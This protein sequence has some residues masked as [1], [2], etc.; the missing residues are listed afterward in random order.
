MAKSFAKT[1]KEKKRY[2]FQPGLSETVDKTIYYLGACVAHFHIFLAPFT[3]H[4]LLE[5][6]QGKHLEKAKFQS[7]GAVDLAAEEEIT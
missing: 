3:D 4:S 6:D 7:L 2:I 5:D 1:K